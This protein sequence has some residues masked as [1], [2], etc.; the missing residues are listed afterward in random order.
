MIVV[1]KTQAGL[2]DMLEPLHDG[3]AIPF[4]GSRGKTCFPII[5]AIIS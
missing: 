4:D 5:P 2:A 1:L 3:T